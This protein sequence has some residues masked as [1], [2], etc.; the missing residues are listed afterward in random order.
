MNI[1]R[2]DTIAEKV[3][4]SRRPHS[5]R[6]SGYIRRHGKRVA[7]LVFDLAEEL[8]A[9]LQLQRDI[10]QVAAL[11]H[12]VGKGFTPHAEIGALLVR[13]YLRDECTPEE[14]ERVA[15]LVGAHCYRKTGSYG[16]DNELHL[17]Q[18]ADILDHFGSQEVWL[19]FAYQLHSDKGPEGSIQFW[20]SKEFRKH[21]DTCRGLLNYGF[22]A[23]E[24][25]RRFEFLAE[26]IRRFGVESE[27]RI[28]RGS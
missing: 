27:G 1:N 17:L 15:F 20:Q 11:F 25:D 19:N 18:D 24:F 5:L 21:I 7:A 22:A 3:M 4:A 16:G 10:L 14:L 2:C 12:D 8:P 6:E 26:F 23:A 13:E 28:Y 9:G